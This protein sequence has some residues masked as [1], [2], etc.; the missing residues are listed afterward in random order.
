MNGVGAGLLLV[1]PHPWYDRIFLEGSYPEGKVI[2]H[3]PYILPGPGA[4]ELSHLKGHN[5]LAMSS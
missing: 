2:G 4:P 3:D 1:D 5:T